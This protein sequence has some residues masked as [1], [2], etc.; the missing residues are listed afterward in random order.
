M[1]NKDCFLGLDISTSVTGICILDQ[2]GNIILVDAL[3]F[4]NKKK[5]PS[6]FKKAEKIVDYCENLKKDFQFQKIT[7][8][9]ALMLF[10]PG[11]S[12]ANTISSL[13]KFNGIVSWLIYDIFDQ[14]PNFISASSARKLNNI[15]IPKGE[16]AKKYVLDYLM[17]NNKEFLP[18]VKYTRNN[19]IS[20]STYDMSDAYIITRASTLTS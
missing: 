8:E 2:T 19:T 17:K 12:S 5:Y 15:K 20:P 18:Y 7:I 14:E 1:N 9:S 16:K 4:K 3:D 10:S 13:L 11:K 6:I